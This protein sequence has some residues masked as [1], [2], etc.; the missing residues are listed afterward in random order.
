MYMALYVI[1]T[2]AFLGFSGWF[3]AAPSLIPVAGMAVSVAGMIGS[4]LTDE[5]RKKREKQYWEDRR[6]TIGISSD[7]V[8][9]EL[10]HLFALRGLRATGRAAEAQNNVAVQPSY[11]LLYRDVSIL[12]PYW[13]YSALAKKTMAEVQVLQ[14]NPNGDVNTLLRVVEKLS[15]KLRSDPAWKKAEQ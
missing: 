15:K 5:E 12:I 2:L 6:L 8:E 9:K 14:Q 7:R 11:D 1:T 3:L 13:T 4:F 10:D